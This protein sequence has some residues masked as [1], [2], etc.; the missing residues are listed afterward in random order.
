MTQKYIRIGNVITMMSG[1]KVFTGTVPGRKDVPSI[2]AAKRESRK[3]QGK[4][5]GCGLLRV[6]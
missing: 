4:S 6:A 3:L 5:L 2:N 1:K